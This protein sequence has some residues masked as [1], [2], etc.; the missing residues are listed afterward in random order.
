VSD[1]VRVLVVDDDDR[2]VELMGSV[3]AHGGAIEVVGRA[4]NGAQG[5][6]LALEL[7]PNVVLMDL[8][9]PVMDGIEATKRLRD[10]GVDAPVIVVSG[11]DVDAH[12]NGAH[13]AGASA[14]VR[15]SAIAEDL[16]EVVHAVAASRA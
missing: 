1:R 7:R 4:R 16:L 8:D 9:M 6:E 2:F 11:S 13:H 14:Y 3:L 5:V 15:K 12:M 10:A